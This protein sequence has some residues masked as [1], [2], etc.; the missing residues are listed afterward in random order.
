[1]SR[2]ALTLALLTIA[3]LAIPGRAAAAR[4]TPGHGTTWQVQFS[5]EIDLS[6]HADTFDLDMFDTPARRVRRLHSSGRHAVCYINAGAWE[7]WRPDAG[8]YPSS[9]KGR[10][11]DGWP[12]ERWLDIRRLDVLAPILTGRLEICSEKGFDGVEFDNVDGYQNA[13]GFDLSRSDQLAFNRWLAHAAHA[14]GLAVGLKNA[15]GIAQELEPDFDFAIVEQCFYFH[16]C[17]LTKPFVDARKSVVV[18][19]YALARGAFCEKAARLGI[20][21]MRKHRDLDA[22]RRPC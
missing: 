16:E 6:V 3:L 8:R 15:L 22:W 11:L 9:V 20:S 10:D 18:I 17:G 14:R 1:M 4:W 7:N 21:A 5:G 13:T 12:G 19:E 2:R